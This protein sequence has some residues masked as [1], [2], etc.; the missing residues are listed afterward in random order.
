[1]CGV[2]K[3]FSL[4]GEFLVPFFSLTLV[5]FLSS[6]QLFKVK[7]SSFFTQMMIFSPNLSFWT[8]NVSFDNFFM[9]TW[10]RENYRK[11]QIPRLGQNSN[12]V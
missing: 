3:T 2:N 11:P 5:L 6:R 7:T 4:G 1:M 9:T 10:E 12:L 8:K